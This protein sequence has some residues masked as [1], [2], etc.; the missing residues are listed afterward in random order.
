MTR[1]PLSVEILNKLD[2]RAVGDAVGR[3]MVV[4]SIWADG[5]QFGRL[6]TAFS[7]K[8]GPAKMRAEP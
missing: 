6:W 4:Y 1:W 2:K 3:Y 7:L 5:K 8:A